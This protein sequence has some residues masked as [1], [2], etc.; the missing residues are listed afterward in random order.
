M[1]PLRT[2]AVV[3]AGGGLITALMRTTRFEVLGQ[4]HYD[5]W[6]GARKPVLLLLWHGRLLP[7]AYYHRHHE[8]ATLISRH[9]D[10]EHIAGVVEGWWGFRAVRGSSSRGGTGA[11]RQM[12][13][14]LRE[15]TAVAVTPDGP[16]GPRQKMKTG[17]IRAAQ[18]A[19]VPILPGSASAERAWWVGTWD[20][21]LIP[22]PFSRIRMIYGEPTFVPREADSRAL[23]AA[24]DAL[25]RQ[26]NSLT[27]RL[28]ASW[29]HA[30]EP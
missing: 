18:L 21:F 14:I 25:E 16:R 29:P 27:E 8:M 7:C 13:R 4:E 30:W 28:D 22:K 23:D 11:L 24:A 19:G 10:G 12:V 6:W 26:L 2:R 1:A 9:R 20:R 5:A 17:P 15:G 3:A